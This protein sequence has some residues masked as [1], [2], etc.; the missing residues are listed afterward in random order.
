M[1]F[2]VTELLVG[3]S[4]RSGMPDLLPLIDS[5]SSQSSDLGVHIFTQKMYD[6]KMVKIYH[7]HYYPL[8][9]GALKEN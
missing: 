9:K 2:F 3:H 6:A 7:Y 5:W 8:L 4:L 1:K